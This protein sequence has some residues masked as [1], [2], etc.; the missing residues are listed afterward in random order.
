LMELRMV[1]LLP[2]E[3]LLDLKSRFGE[4]FELLERNDRLALAIVATELT[5]SHS[6]IRELTGTT[7]LETS[8]MLQNLVK[9]GLIE[10]HNSGRGAIYCLPGAEFPKPE[11]VF[12]SNN[13]IQS[14]ISL[15]TDLSTDILNSSPNFGAKP[16]RYDDSSP[17]FGAKPSRYDD[18]SPNIGEKSD[19][20]VA[21]S[22]K[23]RSRTLSGEKLNNV[24]DKR[25]V[26]GC[27]LTSMLTLPV[28]DDL[29]Q[30][31]LTLLSRLEKQAELPRD[32]RKIEKKAMIEVILNLC[33]GR[34]VTLRC[35]AELVNRQPETL[36]EQYLTNMVKDKRLT[37]AFPTS[38]T[39]ERQA[40]CTTESLEPN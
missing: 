38:P 30:L 17:N 39:H 1:D 35:L 27:L 16:S 4:K 12:G 15:S 10:P 8:R 40:Y 21:Y 19:D 14:E 20:T 25:D 32:K 9:Q 31:T 7:S 3:V 28:I 26:D 2:K 22:S 13:P 18:S 11:E 29:K 33:T 34:Y 24:V 37:M 6:R 36:R 23:Y 5:V